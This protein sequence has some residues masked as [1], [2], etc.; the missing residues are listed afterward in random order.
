M[1][2]QTYTH[3]QSIPSA[4]WTILHNVGS[5]YINIDVVVD[6]NGQLETILPSNIVSISNNQTNV[7]FSSAFSGIARVSK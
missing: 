1:S 5:K 2:I 4:E 3:T 6:Y 7:S